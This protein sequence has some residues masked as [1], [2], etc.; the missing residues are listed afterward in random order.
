MKRAIIL[1][2][3]TTLVSCTSGADMDS[4]NRDFFSD[5]QLNAWQYFTTDSINFSGSTPINTVITAINSGAAVGNVGASLTDTVIAGGPYTIEGV[6]TT[7]S[8]YSISLGSTVSLVI[9]CGTNS[10]L[11]RSFILED[12]SGAVLVAYGLEPPIED[13]AQS[14]SMKYIG[15][16]RSGA[17]APFGARLR[18]TVT[19]GVKYGGGTST[20]PIVTDFSNATIVGAKNS[21]PFS[22][23]SGAYSA[24]DL[25]KMRRIEGY[26]SKVPT[27]SECASSST[28]QFQFNYQKL[29]LGEICTGTVGTCD[30]TGCSVCSGTRF[31]FQMSRDF[32]AGTLT[33]F[34]YGNAFSYNFR[35]AAHVRLTGAIFI[36]EYN[37]AYSAAA[38]MLTQKLQVESLP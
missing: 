4:R 1:F 16:S 31:S 13:T 19:R 9:G 20:M 11:T 3:I 12:N 37:T 5:A 10:V 18:L 34:D 17:M 28:R 32:G 8:N 22:T 33:G 24:A 14:S 35:S 38:L 27:Y 23:I 2:L 30:T 26:I 7:P 21:A 29:Y 36:P 15:N 6:V 25:F